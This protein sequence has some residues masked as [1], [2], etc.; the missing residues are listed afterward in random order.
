MQVEIADIPENSDNKFPPKLSPPEN[1]PRKS[2]TQ[3][4]FQ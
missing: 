4:S 1:K 3:K 2:Q